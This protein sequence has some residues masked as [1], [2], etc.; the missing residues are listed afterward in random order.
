VSGLK[1]LRLA[2]AV[3]AMQSAED[4]RRHKPV[5]TKK[6]GPEAFLDVRRRTVRDTATH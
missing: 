6:N 1:C 2:R 3:R 4:A 5:M